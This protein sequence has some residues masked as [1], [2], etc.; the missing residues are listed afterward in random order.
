MNER[1]SHLIL[2]G[3]IV[4]A[5]VGVALLA[6][7]G[8]PLQRTP[9]LGLDLQGGL[10]VVEKEAIREK[11]ETVD[12]AGLDDAVTIINDRINGTGV[13]EPEIASRAATRSSSSCP[14]STTTSSARPT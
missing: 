14:A 8:S 6:L 1:R 7:P 2:M 9:T 13:S 10:E 12:E 4:A 11:G 3:L 5:L